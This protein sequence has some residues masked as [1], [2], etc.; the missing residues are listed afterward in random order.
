MSPAK[1]NLS[2]AAI[3]RRWREIQAEPA[4]RRKISIAIAATWTLEPW[5]AHLGCSLA[6]RGLLADI[7]VAPFGQLYPSLLDPHGT[8]RAARADVSLVLPRL[9]DLAARELA[10]LALLDPNDA[11]SARAEVEAEIGRLSDAIASFEA[12]TPGMV[13]VGTLPMPT[14]VPLGVL[15]ASHRTSQTMLAR[16]CN[17]ILWRKMQAL[18]RVRLLD[19]DRVVAR[20]GAERAFDARMSVLAACPWSS[21]GLHELAVE[22][23]RAIAALVQP[24]AKVIVLDLDNTLWGG[25]VGEDGRDAIAIG[26]NGLG[27]AFLAFQDALLA[28]RAQGFLLAV[29]SKNN[30]ADAF[31]VFDHHSGM[32]LRRDHFAAH[33][34]GWGPKS[35]ALREL[36]AELSLSTDSFV[37]VDDDPAECAE[38]RAALPEVTVVQL[39]AEPARYV[40]V[41]RAVPQLDR[42]ALTDEDRMRAAAYQAENARAVARKEAATTPDALHAYLRSLQLVAKVR[43]LSAADV[44]RAAQLTQKTNQFNLT[45]IRRSEAE[46]EALLRDAAWRLYALDVADRFGD[47]GTTGLVFA[48]RADATTWNIE[49]LLLSCRVLGRGVENALLRAVAIDLTRAG[50]RRLTGR[51]IATPKN[52]PARNFLAH[53]GFIEVHG[54][55]LL[56]RALPGA[57]FDDGHITLELEEER[58]RDAATG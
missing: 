41:L 22:T 2:P 33:R 32:R 54:S 18:R 51:W 20:L 55:D 4:G 45:T 8:L 14:S 44:S 46:V 43:R 38:V 9:E 36:A 15:D 6:E 26:P 30:E 21:E 35:Q 10:K 27:A 47:Y 39:P 37:F 57:H 52:A 53:H 7:V 19:V 40:E 42:M 12:A 13:L 28:L 17:V 56:V 24:S 23:T 25:I 48:Q 29:A 3:Q 5:L 1:S 50:A 34:V 31:D 49:T 16:E 11:L 58:N